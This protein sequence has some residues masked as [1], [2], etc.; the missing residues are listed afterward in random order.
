MLVMGDNDLAADRGQV[1]SFISKFYKM[2]IG[3]CEQFGNDVE[4]T[5]IRMITFDG[6]I[7]THLACS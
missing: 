5:C 2:C 4:K 6:V 1:V 3:I 7:A